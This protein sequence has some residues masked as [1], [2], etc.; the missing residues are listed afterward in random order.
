MLSKY[1]RP[2]FKTLLGRLE[3]PR[4]FVQV[5]LGPRQVGKTT[6]IRQVEEKVS[7]PS[8]YISADD[9][10]PRDSSWI[11][12]QW[13]RARLL[14]KGGKGALLIIMEPL[15]TSANIDFQSHALTAGVPQP[16]VIR[17]KTAPHIRRF[18]HFS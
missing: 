11:N 3:E 15:G 12:T 9:A 17:N 2:Y 13:Q 14:C 18:I 6:L 1:K 10:I 16:T 5:I 7:S 4:R 8:L